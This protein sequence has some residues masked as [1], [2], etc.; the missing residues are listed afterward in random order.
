MK[1]RGRERVN[2]KD[3]TE[4]RKRR[5]EEEGDKE[6]DKSMRGREGR[7]GNAL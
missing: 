6:G 3:K 2:F 1:M 5:R 4:N 7:E